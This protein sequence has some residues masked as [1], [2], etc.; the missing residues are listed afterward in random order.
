MNTAD[1]DETE[2]LKKRTATTADEERFVRDTTTEW[3]SKL[4]LRKNTG[5]TD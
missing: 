4:V 1:D 3:Y 2:L 5:N